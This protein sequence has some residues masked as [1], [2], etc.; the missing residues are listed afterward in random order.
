M[1]AVGTSTTLLSCTVM[2]ETVAVAP[3]YSPLG[4]PVTAMTTGKAATPDPDEAIM[5]TEETVPYTG[6]VEEAGV[7][8]AWSPG[9]TCATSVS[10]T[11]ALTV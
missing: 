9:F 11:V 3:A 10:S 7:M 5:P 2:I 8:T 1:A 4:V 6:V